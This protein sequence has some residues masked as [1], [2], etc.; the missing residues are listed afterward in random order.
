M[1]PSKKIT[2]AQFE[3]QKAGLAADL[4][5]RKALGTAGRQ[6][7]LASKLKQML[8]PALENI[9]KIV[10]GEPMVEKTVWL[11]NEDDE[12]ALQKLDSSIQFVDDEGGV[13]YKLEY[14]QVPKSQAEMSRWIVT[15]VMATEKHQ[16]DLKIRRLEAKKKALEADQNG[17]GDNS[18]A[19]LKA[20]TDEQGR[21][22]LSL[23]YN[24]EWDEDDS[25]DDDE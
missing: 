19:A 1:C 23:A 5:R 17:Y 3:K 14:F 20:K 12:K 24:P 7:S 10:T 2:D 8:D 11:G 25:E 4:E 16:H 9:R 15:S 13:R 18:P 22:K 21:A 6:A